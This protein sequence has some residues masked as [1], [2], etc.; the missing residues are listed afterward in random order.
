M[1]VAVL[2]PVAFVWGADVTNLSVVYFQYT[3]GGPEGFWV[4]G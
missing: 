2:V 4:Q 1:F 3:L